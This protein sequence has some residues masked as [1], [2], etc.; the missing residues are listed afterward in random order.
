MASY[1]RLRLGE[2]ESKLG[3]HIAH[4]FDYIREGI[5]CAGDATLEG[6]NTAKYPG[7]EIPWVSIRLV[8]ASWP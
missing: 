8:V 3:F 7:V 5:L 4:C 6:N 2:D 1:A